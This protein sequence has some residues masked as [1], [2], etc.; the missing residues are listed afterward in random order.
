MLM[1]SVEAEPCRQ[2]RRELEMIQIKISLKWKNNVDVGH[3]FE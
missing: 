2:I 3:D 1:F